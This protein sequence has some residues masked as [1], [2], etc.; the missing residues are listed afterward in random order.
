M[1]SMAVA[2][3]IDV[4]PW[5][6]FTLTNGADVKLGPVITPNGPCS[7]EVLDANL[8]LIHHTRILL[9]TNIPG[10]FRHLSLRADRLS[11]QLPES[12]V[13]G[14]IIIPASSLPVLALQ[15]NQ[16]INTQLQDGR[17]VIQTRSVRRDEDRAID[18][19]L[20]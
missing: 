5:E 11:L 3:I 1:P 14:Q 10:R 6:G 12:A 2:E 13:A 17:L 18:V 7:V 15:G 9:E 20:P 19:V 8:R 16:A 4:T